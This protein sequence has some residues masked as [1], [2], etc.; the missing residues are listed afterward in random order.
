MFCLKPCG[1]RERDQ[2]ES[3][4][5]RDGAYAIECQECWRWWLKSRTYTVV[6][7]PLNPEAQEVLRAESA[8]F[9]ILPSFSDFWAVCGMLPR[10]M[11]TFPD[12]FFYL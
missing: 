2:K 9:L 8:N 11:W 3:Y 7:V 1:K 6:Q 5:L 12:Y 10:T 4:A